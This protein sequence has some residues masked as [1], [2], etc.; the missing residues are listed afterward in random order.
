MDLGIQS[1]FTR[2][3]FGAGQG[4][5]DLAHHA[6][7]SI[8]TLC[9]TWNIEKN[10]FYDLNRP[11]VSWKSTFQYF[12]F[13]F[14]LPTAP[15][16][17]GKKPPLWESTDHCLS[18][19]WFLC[20]FGMARHQFHIIQTEFSYQGQLCNQLDHINNHYQVV[21]VLKFWNSKTLM[22]WKDTCFSTGLFSNL[23]NFVDEW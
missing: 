10:L 8:V 21:F 9:Y 15:K 2:R 17:L 6:W 18:S 16:R 7:H 22:T 12:C 13:I 5:P 3:C 23:T 4:V 19:M 11:D 14:H 20:R 1:P